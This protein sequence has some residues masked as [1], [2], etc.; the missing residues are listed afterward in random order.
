VPTTVI[1]AIVTIMKIPGL[2]ERDQQP[3]LPCTLAV[4]V[5]CF[6]VHDAHGGNTQMLSK[7]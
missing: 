2:Q 6:V 5:A 4:S 3:Y 1:S 7:Q